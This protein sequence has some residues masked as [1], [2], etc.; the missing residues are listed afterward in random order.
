M[1]EDTPYTVSEELLDRFKCQFY[2]H[3]DDPCYD[4]ND[5]EL[6]GYFQERGRFKMIQR[7]PGVSTTSIT[8]KLLQLAD[9]LKRKETEP[10][11]EDEMRLFKVPPV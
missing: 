4:A 8:G 6:C 1:V 9:Y 2:I 7:T 5:V 3:G 10:P 11:S